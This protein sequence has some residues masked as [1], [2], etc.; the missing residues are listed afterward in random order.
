MFE[1]LRWRLTAWYVLAFTIV[2]VVIGIA[3]FLWVDRRLSD[4]VDSAISDV[5]AQTQLVLA[6]SEAREPAG[7]QGAGLSAAD[8]S[9][10]L[11]DASL[12][13]SADVFILLV[14][15]DGSMAANPG[16]L[17]TK[18]L[19]DGQ[20]IAQARQGSAAWRS[21]ELNGH[22]VR[23]H[24]VPVYNGN[25]QLDGF[26]QTGK[27]LDSRD[28]SLRTLAIVMA[29]GGLAG[30]LLSTIGGLVVAGIAIRPVRRSFERQ[31][32]FVADASHEL[33]TPLTV[34]RTNAET[35]SVLEPK[36]EAVQDIVDESRYMTRLLDDLLMLAGSDQEGIDLALARVDLSDLAR[37]A[38]RAASRLASDAGLTFDAVIGGAMTVRADAER[39][40]EVLLIV[41]DNAVKYTPKGGRITLRTAREKGEAVIGVDDTGVGVPAEEIPRLFDRFYRVDKARS[42]AMGG[43]GLGLSI[44]REIVSAHGGSMQFRSEPGKGSSVIVRLPLAGV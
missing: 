32:E 22:D 9:G 36:D 3:V 6:S 29:G 34:I 42:R 27:S 16:N 18:G 20:S 41:L 12:G 17:P 38:G 8:I 37:S 19:P 5:T 4:E 40:R 33:R 21:E 43:A 28:S 35:L 14:N 15:P 10:V 31:R 30:L 11:S 25:G 26:I 24:T 39:L 44:A 1:A 7:A 2:F 23:L 13:R